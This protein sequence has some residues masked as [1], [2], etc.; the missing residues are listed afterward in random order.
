MG[1]F[2][3]LQ[4]QIEDAFGEEALE[5]D[6]QL[7]LGAAG[8]LARRFQEESRQ[9]FDE[10]LGEA[11]RYL[12]LL[13]ARR[14]KLLE[15]LHGSDWDDLEEVREKV[16]YQAD[17]YSDNLADA[18]DELVT[19]L[20]SQRLEFEQGEGA[21]LGDQPEWPVFQRWSDEQLE[22]AQDLVDALLEQFDEASARISQ[23]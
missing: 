10:L 23:R 5:E 21:R 1:G 14:A 2:G 7:A 4:H 13:V 18:V 9:G 16:G 12:G 8:D 3:A 22:R 6:V 19:R 11:R 17:E 15:R 20:E